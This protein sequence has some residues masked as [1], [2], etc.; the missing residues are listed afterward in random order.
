M[1]KALTISIRS[2][3]F[4]IEEDAYARLDTYLNEIKDHFSN[5]ENTEDIVT[6]IESR[7]AEQL[8]ETKDQVVTLASVEKIIAIMGTVDQFDETTPK[9]DP[10][11]NSS[12]SKLKKLYRNTEDAVIGGVASGIGIYIGKDPLFVRLGFIILT[13]LSGFGVALYFILW[14]LV[15]E[16]KT[17]AQKLEM[18]GAPVTLETLSESVDIQKARSAVGSF[19][20]NTAKISRPIASSLGPVVRIVTGVI[21]LLIGIGFVA[22]SFAALIFLISISFGFPIMG[23]FLL[24]MATVALSIAIPG[25]CIFLVGIGILRNQSAF[26]SAFGITMITLWAISICITAGM[27]ARF[28]GSF[29]QNNQTRIIQIQNW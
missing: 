5:L 3:I 12:P 14:I 25:I 6:D 1:K 28:A 8:L 20:E 26:S 4:T 18:A 17:K 13:L 11:N 9:S 19:F 15:P 2:N 23:G 27:A 22:S 24:G 29:V 10:V 16:A 7:I 21:L